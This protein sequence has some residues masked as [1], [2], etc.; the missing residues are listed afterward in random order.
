MLFQR[1]RARPIRFLP[2]AT[3]CGII[4][5]LAVT[6]AT[7]HPVLAAELWTVAQKGRVF[8]IRSLIIDRGGIIRFSNDDDFPHQI[9]VKGE[10]FTLE[11]DLQEPGKIIDVPFINAGR[12]EVR[13]GIHPRMQMSVQVK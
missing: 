6:T 5:A 7:L 10:G 4:I 11:S 12:F 9:A 13:C 3:S 1:A 8:A 2:R